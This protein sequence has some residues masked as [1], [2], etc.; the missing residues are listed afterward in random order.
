M[1]VPLNRVVA[2]VGPYISLAAGG[3]AAWVVA[4]ANLLGVPGLDQANVATYLTGAGTWALTSG[5]SALGH[6]QWL[7]GHHILL[8][9]DSIDQDPDPEHPA[10]AQIGVT[11]PATIPPDEGDAG[12]AK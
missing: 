12:A 5:L 8:A 1:Q 4:K 7:K 2:F 10:A 6:S 9:S 11:D 3:A